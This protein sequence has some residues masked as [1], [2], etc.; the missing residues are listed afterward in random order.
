MDILPLIQGSENEHLHLAH[1]IDKY[2][3]R[4]SLHKKL[5]SFCQSLSFYRS[6]SGVVLLTRHAEAATRIASLF[7]ERKITKK[8]W[9]AYCD[10]LCDSDMS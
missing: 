1:R 5:T 10:M 6:T 9:L 7:K 4:D 3:G 2:D 8:Y